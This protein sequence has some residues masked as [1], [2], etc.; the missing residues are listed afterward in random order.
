RPARSDL[1]AWLCHGDRRGHAGGHLHSHRCG[2]PAAAPRAVGVLAMADNS[3]QT[4]PARRISTLP[5]WVRRLPAY[6]LVWMWTAFTLAAIAYVLLSA[7]KSKRE[8]L[9]SGW[10]LPQEFIWSNFA[11]AWNVGRLGDYFLNSVMVVGGSVFAIL[12]VSTPAAYV[13][14][15]AKFPG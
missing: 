14:A 5:G 12:L 15:R 13:L 3:L 9:R 1:P 2:A 4:A 6:F 11:T 8:V 10:S 7:V